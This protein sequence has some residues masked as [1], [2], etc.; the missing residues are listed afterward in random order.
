MPS[1][2]QQR[3]KL[4][5]DFVA[6]W[7]QQQHYEILDQH[8]TCRFGEIDIIARKNDTLIFI[9]VRARKTSAFG[10]VLQSMSQSKQQRLAAAIEDYRNTHP[11]YQKML[12]QCD[13][14]A[15]NP[16]NNALQHYPHLS[17]DVET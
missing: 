3:G 1:P 5:E 2:T 12:Y 7:L 15:V 16:I 10:D 9:E 6:Q 17:L 8:Y 13:L 4:A 14:V 11:Q